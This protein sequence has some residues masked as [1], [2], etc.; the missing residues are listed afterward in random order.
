MPRVWL[1]SI[2]FILLIACKSNTASL[3]GDEPV[4]F[5]EFETAFPLLTLPFAAADTN[6]AKIADTTVISR[7]VFTQFVPDSSLQK[8]IDQ[9]IESLTI[10]PVGRI[11]KD[12][13]IYLLATITQNRKVSLVSFLLDKKKKY[14]A[15]LQLVANRNANNGYSYSVVINREPTFTVSREKKQDDNVFYTK[16]GY[17]YNA[18]SGTF[19]KVVDDTNEGKNKTPAIINPIDTLP[20]KNKYSGDYV[21]DKK[22]FISVRDGKNST[23]YEFFIHFEKDDGDCTGELKGEM[24]MRDDSKGFYQGNGDPCV[25]DFNFE[26]NEITLKEQGNCGSHRGIKC[27]FDDTFHKKRE[28]KAKKMSK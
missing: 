20:R 27:Y 15:A 7:T 18:E 23:R 13:Y 3:S 4:S 8:F 2:L 11:E 10:N 12:N 28:G 26:D 1:V 6:V 21:R 19:I 24:A 25:I 5:K 14:I 17:A 9:N 22:N 16:T